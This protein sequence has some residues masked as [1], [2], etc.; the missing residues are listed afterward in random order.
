MAPAT[1]TGAMGARAMTSEKEQSVSSSSLVVLLLSAGKVSS[2]KKESRRFQLQHGF[3]RAAWNPMSC[4]PQPPEDVEMLLILG[5]NI[6]PDFL[7]TPFPGYPDEH[8]HEFG[9]KAF[10]LEPILHENGHFAGC[11]VLVHEK[12]CNPYHAFLSFFLYFCNYRHVPVVVDITEKDK[13]FMGYVFDRWR[14]TWSSMFLQTRKRASRAPQARLQGV[15]PS[16]ALRSRPT[17]ARAWCTWS[18]RE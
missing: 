14:R 9:P 2:S 11:Q 6:C 16:E 15:W 4:K 10:P 12:P 3:T 17:G 5:K 18:D 8:L 7:K 1:P 13:P